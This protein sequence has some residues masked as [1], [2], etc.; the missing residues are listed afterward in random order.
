MIDAGLDVKWDANRDP[1][2][3]IVVII[4]TNTYGT[5][6]YDGKC[7]MEYSGKVINSDFLIQRK[8]KRLVRFFFFCFFLM[9]DTNRISLGKQARITWLQR[10]LNGAP[11]MPS[12]FTYMECTTYLITDWPDLVAGSQHRSINGNTAA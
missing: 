4:L 12:T 6:D 8:G 7:I 9:T 2:R 11:K 5:W 1:S 10:R 3:K